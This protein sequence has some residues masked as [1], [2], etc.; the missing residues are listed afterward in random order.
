MFDVRDQ[1]LLEK[2][3]ESTER[4][5]VAVKAVSSNDEIDK[6][7]FSPSRPVKKRKEKIEKSTG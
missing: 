7:Y 6:L 3:A 1:M 2:V 4:M 5:Q